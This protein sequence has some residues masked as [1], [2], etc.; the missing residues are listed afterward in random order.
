[1]IMWLEKY[2]GLLWRGLCKARGLVRTKKDWGSFKKALTQK[3]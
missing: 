3:F 1:M 2:C